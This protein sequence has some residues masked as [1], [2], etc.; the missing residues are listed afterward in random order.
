MFLVVTLAVVAMIAVGVIGAV[1]A[2]RHR[3]KPL[4]EPGANLTP[5]VAAALERASRRSRR[6]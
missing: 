3:R 6:P 1:I 4:D 2:R 5:R